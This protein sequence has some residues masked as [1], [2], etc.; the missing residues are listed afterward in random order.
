M[1]TGV[2]GGDG[3]DGA[4]GGGEPG[5]GWSSLGGTAVLAAAVSAVDQDADQGGGIPGAEWQERQEMLRGLAGGG[6]SGR[7][8]GWGRRRRR[9]SCEVYQAW[10][11]GDLGLAEEKQVRVRLAAERMEG[12]SW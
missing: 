11:D 7:C 2:W 1:T 6:E 9:R 3:A 10:K 5:A 4:A 8:R 12:A